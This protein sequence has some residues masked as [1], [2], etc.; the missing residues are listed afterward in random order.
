MVVPL[1][2]CLL[3]QLNLHQMVLFVER[4]AHGWN[5]VAVEAWSS[6]P[7]RTELQGGF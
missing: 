4:S 3:I 6:L 5:P 1:Q 7:D 2:N